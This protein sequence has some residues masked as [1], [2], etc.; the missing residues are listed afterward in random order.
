VPRE[1]VAVSWAAR[2][3][4]AQRSSDIARFRATLAGLPPLVRGA[5]RERA[6]ATRFEHVA[7]PSAVRWVAVGLAL[8]ALTVPLG[9]LD[10]WPAWR[11]LAAGSAVVR[12]S[13][14]HASRPRVECKPLTAQ[15]MADLKPNM[16]RQVGCPRERWPTYVEL[17]R[18]GELLYRGEHQPAG[19]WDDG[20][21]TIYERFDVPA[22]P[23]QLTVRLRDS[24]RAE[25]FDYERSATVDLEPEQNLV[26][27]FSVGEGPVFH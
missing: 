14:S 4:R 12:L 5:K 1:R 10:N 24:G 27:G 20:P 2:G 8:A 7:W 23:Q 3:H 17:E 13:F 16:R 19:L 26:I 21:A 11:Q 9:V 25:G 6:P 22:G 18:N 15:E